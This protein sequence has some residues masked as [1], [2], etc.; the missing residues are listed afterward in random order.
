ML[1]KNNTLVVSD[2]EGN[3]H[4]INAATAKFQARQKGDLKG[5][6]V[7]PLVSGNSV[8]LI[9]KTGLLSKFTL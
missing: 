5:Y 6:S 1:I 9:G 4:F 3:I 2:I 8:Y 7:E